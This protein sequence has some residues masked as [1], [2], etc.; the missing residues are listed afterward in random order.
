MSASAAGSDFLPLAALGVSLVSFAVSAATLYIAH[1]RPAR[2]SLQIGPKFKLY[3]ADGRAL[4]FYFPVTFFNRSER[5]GA[6]ASLELILVGP[7]GREFH[8]P[9]RSFSQYD[10][11]TNSWVYRDL[12]KT[13]AVPG[14]SSFQEMVWFSWPIESA[15]QPVVAA[16]RHTC[17][18]RYKMLPSGTF[19]EVR[20]SFLVSAAAADRL[21][22]Y[23][24]GGS[25]STL[26]FDVGERPDLHEVVN[27]DGSREASWS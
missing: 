17:R 27:P 22:A 5:T 2:L 10:G 23:R 3:Y 6:V 9:W 18:F 11:A 24:A 12:V 14:S 7:D 4:S 15:I 19:G 13:I 21:A 8:F 16:G 20:E 25:A 26:D 1:V